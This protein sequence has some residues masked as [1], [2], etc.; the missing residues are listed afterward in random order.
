MFSCDK[1]LGFRLNYGGDAAQ[2]TPIDYLVVLRPSMDCGLG[3][4]T[5]IVYCQ[6]LL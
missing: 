1:I 3:F 2:E 4:P 6:L 5:A